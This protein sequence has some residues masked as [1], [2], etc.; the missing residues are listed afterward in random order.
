[1]ELD[2][3]DIIQDAKSTQNKELRLEVPTNSKLRHEVHDYET[4]RQTSEVRREAMLESQNRQMEMGKTE[5]WQRGAVA[6]FQASIFHVRSGIDVQPLHF[7]INIQCGG[8][9]VPLQSAAA[10]NFLCTN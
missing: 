9:F 5:S 6:T 10:T 2:V 8:T 7:K 4:R 3:A 1:M